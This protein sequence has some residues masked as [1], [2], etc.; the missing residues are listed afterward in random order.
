MPQD[1]C[2][3]VWQRKISEL[4]PH[5][6]LRRHRGLRSGFVRSILPK[7][8][9]RGV[10]G[11]EAMGGELGSSDLE[12]P[13]GEAVPLPEL[14]QSA[15]TLANTQGVQLPNMPVYFLPR[16]PGLAVRL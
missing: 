15:A 5:K 10:E 4:D 6:R 1:D 11:L 7:G 16:A 14:S 2:H 8:D 9:D 12:D 13:L 3:V